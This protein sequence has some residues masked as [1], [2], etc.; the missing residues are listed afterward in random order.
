MGR[1]GGEA[2]GGR[3]RYEGTGTGAVGAGQGPVG[4]SE[5]AAGRPGGLEG[6]GPAC[7]YQPGWVAGQVA[8]VGYVPMLLRVLD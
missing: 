8:Q 7:R 2:G 5:G 1:G 4:V 3:L 6:P